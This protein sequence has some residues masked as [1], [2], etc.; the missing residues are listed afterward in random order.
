MQFHDDSQRKSRCPSSQDLITETH[1]LGAPSSKYITSLGRPVWLAHLRL[2]HFRRPE[3]H[4][5]LTIFNNA[6]LFPT[7]SMRGHRNRGNEY[8]S[9]ASKRVQRPTYEPFRSF[10]RGKMWHYHG[11]DLAM[12]RC[13]TRYR[14][15][16]S[17]CCY[18]WR[19]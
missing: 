11:K 12:K 4:P 10:T 19:T 1:H 13:S 9:S 5:E 15:S 18:F 3:I 7:K 2:K 17:I 6:T 14:R 16:C 8:Y